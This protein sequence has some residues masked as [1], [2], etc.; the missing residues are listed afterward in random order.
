[1]L[2]HFGAFFRNSWK[3]TMVLTSNSVG[4][5]KDKMDGKPCL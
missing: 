5:L 3:E 1:M 4:G 2:D